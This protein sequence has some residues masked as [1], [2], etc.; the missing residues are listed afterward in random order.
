VVELR[1]GE[2]KDFS[3]SYEEYLERHGQD[4]MRK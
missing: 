4:Y 2:V 3:G 1:Q